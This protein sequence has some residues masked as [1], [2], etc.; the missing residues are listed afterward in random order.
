MY[1]FLAV[2][3]NGRNTIVVVVV[4]VV[5]VVESWAVPTPSESV[6]HSVL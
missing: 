2:R 1:L 5:V 4:V 6:Q 3:I